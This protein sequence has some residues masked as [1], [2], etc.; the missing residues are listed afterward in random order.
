MDLSRIARGGENSRDQMNLPENFEPSETDVICGRGSR[1]FNHPGNE[2]FR[3]LVDTYVNRYDNAISKVEKGYM[4]S[5]IVGIVRHNSPDGGFVKKDP[6]TERWY[7]VGDFVA[8]EK[9]SQTFRDALKDKYR[10][11]NESKKL[12]R[13]LSQNKSMERISNSTG[14]LSNQP[15]VDQMQPAGNAVWSN[16][17][18]ATFHRTSMSSGPGLQHQGLSAYKSS[19]TKSAPH[20][21]NIITV[22]DIDSILAGSGNNNMSSN[23][24]GWSSHAAQP[25]RVDP[26]SAFKQMAKARGFQQ[27]PI[28]QHQAPVPAP[29][30]TFQQESLLS[31]DQSLPPLDHN[32]PLLNDLIHPVEGD[33][34]LFDQLAEFVAV[35]DLPENIDSIFDDSAVDPVPLPHEEV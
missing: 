19:A 18:N 23:N 5:E 14:R 22:A 16:A 30:P 20:L 24:Y 2:R 1:A 32:D 10:S 31:L 12:R 11:S 34:E 28:V 15:N 29:M 13:Q 8:R 4:L 33:E 25:K 3:Q 6:A 7:E 9:V 21:N 35:N 27:G 26:F 17:M